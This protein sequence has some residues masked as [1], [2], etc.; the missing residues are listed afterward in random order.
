MGCFGQVLDVKSGFITVF[1]I[2]SDKYDIV[3]ICS[4]ENSVRLN[5]NKFGG[6]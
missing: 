5:F 1:S 2:N 4:S 3:L 6:N